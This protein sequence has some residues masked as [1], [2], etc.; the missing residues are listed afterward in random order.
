MSLREQESGQID[1]RHYDEMLTNSRRVLR[2]DKD[3]RQ[4][5]ER[6]YDVASQAISAI[7][8][9]TTLEG[10]E[11]LEIGCGP[12]SP[13]GVST[14][15]FLNG[16]DHAF[17]IDKTHAN[18]QRSAEALYD[19]LAECALNPTRWNINNLPQNEFTERLRK[20]DATAL[21]NGDLQNG[22]SKVDIN[23]TLGN[24]EEFPFADNSFLITTSRA[25]LEHVFDFSKGM[26]ELYRIIKPGGFSFHSIDLADHR[27]Y[28]RPQIYNMWSFLQED[29]TWTDNLV[30]LSK[31]AKNV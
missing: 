24:I 4:G 21:R 2:N 6:A 25:T 19:L 31:Q 8:K 3:W 16:V 13:L 29:E 23:Y 27:F 22:I 30:N 17:A 15:M 14:I 10:K 20:F 11:Y 26:S 18:D 9:Q 12:Y 28:K 7:K 5:P 1:H